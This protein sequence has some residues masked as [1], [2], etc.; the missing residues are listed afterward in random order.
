M[1]SAKLINGKIEII[2]GRH[3]VVEKVI[4]GEYVSNDVVMDENT[5][6]LL[7]ENI[8]IINFLILFH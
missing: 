2:D 4:T 6:I 8:Y 3:P 7:M 5:N 1:K